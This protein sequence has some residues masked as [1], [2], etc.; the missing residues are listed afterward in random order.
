VPRVL[1]LSTT[2]GYQ[3]RSFGDAAE[4]AGID[5]I[6]ATDRCHRLDDPWRDAA[7]PV[8]FHEEDASLRAIVDAARARPIDGVLAVGDRPV[9][10]AAR[11]AQALGLPGNPP[12]AAAASANKRLVRQRFAAAGLPVPWFFDVSRA[13]AG[14]AV[15]D[16]RLR[17]PCVVKPLGLSGSR[18]VMRANSPA[19]LDAAIARLDALLSR[20]D[21]RALRSGLEETMLVEGF[22]E[23]REVAV[24]GVLTRGTLQAF[25][26]FDK[27]DPLDGPFFEE[28]I[29]VTPSALPAATQQAVFEHVQRA[30]SALGLTDGPVHAECRIGPGGVFVLEAAARPIGGLCSKVLRFGDVGPPIA[31]RIGVTPPRSRPASLEDVLLRHATGRDITREVRESRAAGVMMIPIPQRGTLKSVEGHDAA[32]AVQGIEEVR[33]TAK[34]DQLLEPLPEAGSYLGFIFGR[35]PDPA[36]VVS[37]LKSAHARL[38]FHIA[39]PIGVI[40]PGNEERRTADEERRTKNGEPF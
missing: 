18:G 38:R 24:E 7:V 36:T 25:A 8:R 27:P 37:A 5:L 13:E 28:T 10:L 9:V 19:E 12:E 33:I 21:V 11:A 16:P 6:F 23:G 34:R 39:T 14:S 2:T 29:Y 35:G 30:A 40:D 4:R 17:F 3:L 22:I 1:I 15:H 20:K 26:I 32:A 31:N